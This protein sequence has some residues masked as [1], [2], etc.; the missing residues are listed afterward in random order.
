MMNS[1]G[2]IVGV[3]LTRT[4]IEVCTDREVAMMRESTH[5]LDVE[6]APARQM[7]D[8]HHARKRARAGR[9]GD[10]SSYWRS[11]V[12]LDGDVLADYTSVK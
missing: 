3:A 11:V 1:G 4:F 2:N 12:A 5:S 10:V 8:K 9:L 7:M 6:L